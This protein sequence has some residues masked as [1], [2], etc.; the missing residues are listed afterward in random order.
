MVVQE[1]LT[2]TEVKTFAVRGSAGCPRKACS[3]RDQKEAFQL[4]IP[5]MLTL[6]EVREYG[7]LLLEVPLAVLERLPLTEVRIWLL[8]CQ[9][10]ISERLTLA[11]VRQKLA[12]GGSAGGQSLTVRRSAG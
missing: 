9:L 12:I 11:E 1:R 2:I 5:E 8:K 7:S 10:A 4:T 6:T 3:Y